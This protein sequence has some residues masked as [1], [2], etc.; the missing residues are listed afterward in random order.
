MTSDMH[1]FQNYKKWPDRAFCH[2]N[3]Q[4]AMCQFAV[5]ASTQKATK[6]PWQSKTAKNWAKHGSL[7][8]KTGKVMSVDQLVFP[9]PGLIAQMTGFIAKQRYRYATVY[10]DQALGLSYVHLQK[11][12]LADET[13]ESK[14]A[15]ERFALN[16]GVIIMNY[17]ADNGIFKANAWVQ[18]CRRKEQGLTFAAVGAHHTIG[19]AERRIRELQEMARTMLIH[20]NHRWPEAVSVAHRHLLG[21]IAAAQPKC[22]VGVEPINWTR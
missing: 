9:T 6:R 19:K 5:H 20:A 18:A 2:P 8:L 3:W 13:L 14:V 22:G 16:R 17:H 21:P 7:P 1:H 11:T 4:S 10:V 12:A 15:F